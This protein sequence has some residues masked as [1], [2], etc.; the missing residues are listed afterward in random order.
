MAAGKEQ[1]FKRNKRGEGGRD[2]GARR[3]CPSDAKK[4][5]LLNRGFYYAFF[6]RVLSI[7][8]SIT[9]EF[10]IYIN[11]LDRALIIEFSI[12]LLNSYHLSLHG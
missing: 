9:F 5:R 7:E 6:A 11:V 2:R 12:F 1:G 8:L 3:P 10:I 4:P